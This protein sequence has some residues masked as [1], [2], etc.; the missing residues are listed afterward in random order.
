MYNRG[1]FA[2]TTIIQD[3]IPLISKALFLLENYRFRSKRSLVKPDH[4]LVSINIETTCA[5]IKK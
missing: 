3:T 5:V 4:V 2:T 1:N